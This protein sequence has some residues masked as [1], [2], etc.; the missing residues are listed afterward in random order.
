VV[1]GVGI[2]GIIIGSL[3]T[4]WQN[5]KI[6]EQKNKNAIR[7]ENQ[8]IIAEYKKEEEFNSRIRELVLLELRTYSGLLNGL[9]H[10]TTI[11]EHKVGWEVVLKTPSKYTGMSLEKRVSVFHLYVLSKVEYAY[12]WFTIFTHRFLKK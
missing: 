2:G 10:T 8:R 7:L 9:L 11:S 6:E 3:F 12:H 1:A 5:R 4:Y